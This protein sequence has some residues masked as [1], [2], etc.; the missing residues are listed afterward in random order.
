MSTIESHASE[1][2]LASCKGY[3]EIP[4]MKSCGDFFHFCPGTNLELGSSLEM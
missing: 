1:L 4:L 2:L 3:D